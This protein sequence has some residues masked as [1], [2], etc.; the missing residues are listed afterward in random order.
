MTILQP[1]EKVGRLIAHDLTP[2]TAVG[3][4][5]RNIALAV[6]PNNTTTLLSKEKTVMNRLPACAL[7]RPHTRSD[8]GGLDL[9]VPFGAM[10]KGT[11]KNAYKN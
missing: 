9:L 3:K 5:Q 6:T 11:Y 1:K 7:A 4:G 2:R 10:P 8:Y